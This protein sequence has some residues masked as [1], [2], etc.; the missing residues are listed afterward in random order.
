LLAW[1]WICS[2]AHILTSYCFCGTKSLRISQPKGPP[3]WKQKQSQLL[4][5]PSSLKNCVMDG[6][7]K[8]LSVNF[9]R[10]VFCLS[11]FLILEDRIGRLS[12]NISKELP[13]CAAWYLRRAQI[14]HDDLAVHGPVPRAPVWHSRAQN[15]SYAN[16]RLP[17]RFFFLIN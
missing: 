4:K 1:D 9:S 8:I 14:S 13:L 6:S 16:L 11:D 17:H 15:V 3:G 10:A 2:V 12:Q 7:H 5:C